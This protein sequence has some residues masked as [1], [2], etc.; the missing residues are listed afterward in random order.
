MNVKELQTKVITRMLRLHQPDPLSTSASTSSSPPSFDPLTSGGWKVLIYDQL[1]SDILSPL[2]SVSELRRLGITLHINIKQKRDA[3]PD[4]P[5]VYFLSPTQANIDALLADLSQSL[6]SGYHLHFT[7]SIPRPLLGAPGDE[8]CGDRR[9]WT[10]R[11]R[12]RRVRA[13]RVCGRTAV[14]PRP[15]TLVRH[16][17]RYDADGRA[18]VGVRGQH[19][20]LAL[21]SH[22][23]T[24][25]TAYHS[26]H[27]PTAPLHSLH[28]GWTTDCAHISYSDRTCSVAV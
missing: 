23:H 4:T 18:H 24:Q 13:V 28:S 26:A 5:A 12:V 27:S 14:P 7:S 21:L 10:H 1:G 19:S 3:V 11:T 16:A 22:R 25:H 6:Y 2:L 15:L 9:E 17:Q 20:R 8:E